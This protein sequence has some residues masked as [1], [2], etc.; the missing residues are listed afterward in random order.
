MRWTKYAVLTL[1]NLLILAAM[2]AGQGKPMP[3]KPT[4]PLKVQVII[5]EYKGAN[6]VSSLPYT[7]SVTASD[8]YSGSSRLRMRLHVPAAAGTNGQFSYQNVGTDIDCRGKILGRG[9]FEIELTVERSSLYPAT[10]AG[11]APASNGPA[12]SGIAAHQPIIS[13]F[14]TDLHLV[15][16]DGET[17]EST[18]ATDP[19]SGRVLKVDVT[20]HVVK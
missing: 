5:K 13:S 10:A 2:A 20:L 17:I 19:V 3:E 9:L 1:V 4:V 6:E 7:V 15:M 16:R 12:L 14:L 18:M 8:Q 11:S